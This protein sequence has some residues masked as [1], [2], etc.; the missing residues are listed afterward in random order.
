MPIKNCDIFITFLSR[1]YQW[2]ITT[3]VT[4][5]KL[6]FALIVIALIPFS[7]FAQGMGDWQINVSAGA[8]SAEV[9]SKFELYKDFEFEDYEGK[10]GVESQLGIKVGRIETSWVLQYY[11]AEKDGEYT[12]GVDEKGEVEFYNDL[13]DIGFYII[14][15]PVWGGLTGSVGIGRGTTT[16]VYDRDVGGVNTDGEFYAKSIHYFGAVN[17]HFLDWLF[18]KFT[19]RVVNMK[20]VNSPTFGTS[21]YSLTG[22]VSF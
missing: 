8:N 7:G 10:Y 12:S 15:E 16:V 21:A 9:D 19:Y 22:G 11:Y 18:V 17:Y 6:I 1:K 20:N 14:D 2:S 3:E 4:M 13:L 5:K